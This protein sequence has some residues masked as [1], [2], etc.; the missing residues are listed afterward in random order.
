M[1]H[2]PDTAVASALEAA[3]ASSFRLL[4][5]ELVVQTQQGVRVLDEA[6]PVYIYIYIYTCIYVYICDNV[7][8]YIYIEIERE[9]Y[10]SL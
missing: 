10:L 4:E 8:V 6:L 3:S 5:I 7:C 9:Y 2:E 1:E